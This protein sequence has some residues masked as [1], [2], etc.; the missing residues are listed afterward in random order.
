LSV[1]Q[2]RKKEVKVASRALANTT[3]SCPHE[4]YYFTIHALADLLIKPP[5]EQL[6]SGLVRVFK[7]ASCVILGASHHH[8]GSEE[9]EAFWGRSRQGFGKESKVLGRIYNL[10]LG[11]GRLKTRE[12]T[13]LCGVFRTS[14][15]FIFLGSSYAF[16]VCFHSFCVVFLEHVELNPKVT[17]SR[18]TLGVNLW[19]FGYFVL[20]NA[21]GLF[22]IHCL[23][24][25]HTWYIW[26]LYVSKDLGNARFH[27]HCPSVR[28]TKLWNRNTYKYA[29]TIGYLYPSTPRVKC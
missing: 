13:P 11:F 28:L 5:R 20:I 14:P 22:V 17:G 7:G 16:R 23:V 1:K 4:G 9:E 27:D 6:L 15:A 19:C 3:P 25:L 8:S 10:E 24:F 21:C 29:V 26:E 18:W 2:H 12:A